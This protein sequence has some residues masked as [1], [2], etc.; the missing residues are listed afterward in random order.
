MFVTT[1][2]TIP[3]AVFPIPIEY[4][5]HPMLDDIN[6]HSQFVYIISHT[7]AAQRHVLLKY[8]YII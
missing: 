8:I 5:L 3:R 6:S 4:I 7:P 1:V 2:Y